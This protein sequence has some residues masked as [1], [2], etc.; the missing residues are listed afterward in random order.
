M[1]GSC[2]KRFKPPQRL[3]VSC[4]DFYD[5]HGIATSYKLVNGIIYSLSRQQ[6][7]P[8]GR[9]WYRRVTRGLGRMVPGHH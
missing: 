7:V 9:G 6:Y 8:A 2:L 3:R 4:S 1:A 5:F